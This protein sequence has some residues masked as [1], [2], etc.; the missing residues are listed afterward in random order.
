METLKNGRYLRNLCR[1]C[2][3][4]G[5]LY[6]VHL[7]TVSAAINC[8][9][10]VTFKNDTT[11]EAFA[12]LQNGVSF[13]GYTMTSC[14][15][16]YSSQDWKQKYYNLTCSS[17][18]GGSFSRGQF[19]CIEVVPECTSPQVLNPYTKKCQ[20][21]CD[22]LYQNEQK[23]TYTGPLESTVICLNGCGFGI[24]NERCTGQK[25]DGLS[26]RLYCEATTSNSLG[27]MCAD[28]IGGVSGAAPAPPNPCQNPGESCCLSRGLA[29][30]NVNGVGTC[31]TPSANNPVTGSKPVTTT[32][33]TSTGGTDFNTFPG[34]PPGTV[35]A[36]STASTKWEDQGDT[37]KSRT[38][39]KTTATNASGVSSTSTTQT[40]KTQPKADFCKENPNLDLCKTGAFGGKCGAFTC[41]GDA[42]QCAIAKETYQRNCTLFDDKTSTEYQN[43]E[44]M[45]NGLDVMD[46][47]NPLDPANKGTVDLAG[48]AGEIDT[49]RLFASA[50]CLPNKSVDVLGHSVTI[51]SSKFCDVVA[52]MGYLFVAVATLNAARIIKGGIE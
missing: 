51:D 32:G 37:I 48:T 5:F 10:G 17:T 6:F 41:D 42:V 40:E 11:P 43:F 19:Q 50:Q 1:N 44:K 9:D 38:E 3:M 31:V 46:G 2:L 47:K 29:Y 36:S 20:N 7:T 33:T 25:T 4:L 18:S 13:A 16:A 28:G 8:N 45:R 21:K 35:S 26:L 34:L 12:A 30:Q 27:S 15:A 23:I 39:T 14:T 52:L 22:G 49:K 24:K